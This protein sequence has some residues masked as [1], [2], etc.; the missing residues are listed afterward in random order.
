MH[1]NRI[2][3]VD[4]ILVAG[5]SWHFASLVV[6]EIGVDDNIHR[7][8][9]NLGNCLAIHCVF[10]VD[11]LLEVHLA[12]DRILLDL[13][14]NDVVFYVLVAEVELETAT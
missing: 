2:L 13:V 7:I 4:R 5:S 3:L 1:D 14:V 12:L 8:Y 10:E 6:I 11:L 9:Y